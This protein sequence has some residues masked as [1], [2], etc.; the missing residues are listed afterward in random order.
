MASKRLTPEAE[1]Q[2]IADAEANRDDE[3]STLTKTTGRVAPDA[4]AVLSVRMPIEQV[5]TLRN[6]ARE[7][8]QTLSELVQAAVIGLI[9]APQPQVEISE[10]VSRCIVYSS[11]G[12][13]SVYTMNSS[14]S[15]ILS[16]TPEQLPVTV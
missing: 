1:A 16:R 2:L 4:S 9:A 15:R 6:V 12:P 8:N 7:R 10:A 3:T 5:R 14:E 11:G 13:S